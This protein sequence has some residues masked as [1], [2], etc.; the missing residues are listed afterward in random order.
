[1]SKLGDK[2]ISSIRSKGKSLE[3]EMSFFEHLEALRWHLI[4]SAFAIVIFAIF[5][6]A[7]YDTIFDGIVMAP[8]KKTF[9]TYR[10]ICNFGEWLHG[11]IPYFKAENFCVSQDIKVSLLNTEL[12]GQF[13]LQIN[14]AIVIGITLGIPYILYEI[15]KFVRPA[16][17]EKER[18]SASGFVFYSSMLFALGILFGYYVV[19]PLAV[20]FLAGY[21]VSASIVNMFS[22]DSF[23][24]SVTMLTLASGIAFQLP[25]LVYILA[26][27]GILTP[28][29]MRRTRRYA[30]II[31][32]ILAAFIT[33]TPDAMTMCVVALPLLILYE[34]SILVAAAVQRR[35]L[36]NDELT[37]I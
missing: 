17:H 36:K 9:F 1:M 37:V 12:A 33:P 3:G 29:F 26:R 19:T 15:W 6:F 8:T 34:V 27:V 14:S 30:V 31:I 35:K 24:S 22:I 4:R 23:V 28:Q 21:T 7:Y 13:T 5:A 32:L 18:R 20:K 2:I 25:I 10:M 11:L 16:L